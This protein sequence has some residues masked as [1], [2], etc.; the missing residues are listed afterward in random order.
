MK[1]FIA[2][3]LIFSLLFG[4]NPGSQSTSLS[5]T[6]GDEIEADMF[7]PL[8]EREI[9]PLEEIPAETITQ[10][11]EAAPVELPAGSVVLFPSAGDQQSRRF[12]LE[13][14]YVLFTS[15][16]AAFVITEIV[17]LQ[18]RAARALREQ[19]TRDFARLRLLDEQWRLQLNSERERFRI[20]HEA[21]RAEVARLIQLNQAAIQ[22]GNEIPWENI[23]IS[24][25]IFALGAVI[26]L[27][28][29]LVIT[30]R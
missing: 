20:I 1:K 11:S 13:H 12:T 29:G 2:I 3:F 9:E 30:V 27:V 10:S 7:S 8:P 14:S 23:L 19:R 6:S 4:C 21:D 22:R 16:A 5:Q 18:E 26:G 15:S 24:I 17:A 28:G 25:G